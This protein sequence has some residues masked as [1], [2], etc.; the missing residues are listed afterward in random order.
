[1]ILIRRGGGGREADLEARWKARGLGRDHRS[2][3]SGSRR[4]ELLKEGS[5]TGR[6]P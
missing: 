3:M 1:M 5:R 4:W 6:N 2:D